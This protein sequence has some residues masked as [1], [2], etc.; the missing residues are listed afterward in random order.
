MGA[1][2]YDLKNYKIDAESVG[3]FIVDHYSSI[4]EGE[5]NFGNL[6][7]EQTSRL[8]SNSFFLVTSTDHLCKPDDYGYLKLKHLV[9][10]TAEIVRG[11]VPSFKCFPLD[12]DRM[13]ELVSLSVKYPNAGEFYALCEGG[14][15]DM[16]REVKEVKDGKV[17]FTSDTWTSLNT[18]HQWT[19]IETSTLSVNR[20]DFDEHS[21]IIFDTYLKPKAPSEPT[22]TIQ[23]T[24]PMSKVK[25]A[26]AVAVTA[27][28]TA[29][30][31]AAKLKVGK[32]ANN[33]VAK[34]IK[35]KMP[36]GTKGLIDH[37][38]AGIAIANAAKIAVN[39][40]AGDNTKAQAIVDAMMTY[41]YFELVDKIDVEGM[42]DEMTNKFSGSAVE[43]IVAAQSDDDIVIDE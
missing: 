4:E 28:K 19:K 11:E 12:V 26:A 42:I 31:E 8:P 27:N 1:F 14:E 20:E 13:D 15:L 17:Y 40:M 7:F 5:N 9:W 21:Q 2:D 18:M 29:G 6:E 25:A 24:K 35:P 32:T 39:Q 41:S 22:Q 37:P 38:L 34:M 33:L 43:K 36:V 3:C 16:I 23:E 10:S 30:I